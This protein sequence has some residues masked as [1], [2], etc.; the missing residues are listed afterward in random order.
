MCSMTSGENDGGWAF[1]DEE[2]VP[3]AGLSAPNISTEPEAIQDSTDPDV[4][5]S[6]CLSATPPDKPARATDTP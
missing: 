3:E 1:A 4:D 2:A 6:A 5:T